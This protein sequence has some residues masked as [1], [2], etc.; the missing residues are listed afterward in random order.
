MKMI[1]NQRGYALLIV[2]LIITVI[3]IFAP[4]LI[5]NL[6][7]SSIQFEKAEQ[8]IQ[9]QKMKEMG[10]MYA[11]RALVN[12]RS[13]QELR[14]YGFD[15]PDRSDQASM[16]IDLD[17]RTRFHILIENI[18]GTPNIIVTPYVDH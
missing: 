6:M 9:M 14:E 15:V 5:S 2:L 13:N 18:N 10:E 7:N 17:P 3:G 1:K 8:D 12:A 11:E 16:T 4:I